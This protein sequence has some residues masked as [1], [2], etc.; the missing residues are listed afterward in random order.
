MEV[1]GV[2]NSCVTAFRK[3]SCRSLRRTSR[4]RKMVLRTTPA[5]SSAKKGMPMT[6]GTRR[7]QLRMIQPTLSVTATPTRHAPSTMN[8]TTFRLR[9][10][11]LMGATD[12]ARKKNRPLGKVYRA[13]DGIG[14]RRKFLCY[15]RRLRIVWI[16]LCDLDVPGQAEFLEQPDAVIVWINLV[17]FQAVAR[18]NGMRMMIVVP[19]FTAREQGDPPAV[20][21]VVAGF[22]ASRSPHVRRGIH[23]P[24][25]VQAEGHAQEDSPHDARPATDSEQGEANDYQRNP[26]IFTEPDMKLVTSEVGSIARK[27]GGLVVHGDAAH[28][29]AHVSPPSA[30][31]RRVRVTLVIGKLVMN[32]VRGHPEDRAALERQG[33]ADGHE[34]FDPLGCLVAAMSQQAVVAHSDAEVRGP[35]P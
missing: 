8:S 28:D 9:P 6:R 20:A 19:S 1:I 18:G 3:L 25:S 21:R 14:W 7:R 35:H 2:F 32:A 11:I 12:T 24:G 10:L 34:I 33:R 16:E 30:F 5:M 27:H 23:Q 17:P 31:G 15:S 29:P 22:E 4:T 26:V 13:G